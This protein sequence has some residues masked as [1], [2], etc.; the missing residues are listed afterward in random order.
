M[1]KKDPCF[2]LRMRNETETH[3][4]SA[5]LAWMASMR[6]NGYIFTN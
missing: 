5:K 4:Q 3:Y 1:D 2:R 6:R